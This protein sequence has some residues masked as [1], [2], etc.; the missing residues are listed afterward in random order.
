MRMR[1]AS[2]ARARRTMTVT[3]SIESASDVLARAS[4]EA[5]SMAGTMT[6]SPRSTSSCESREGTP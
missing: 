3:S 2:Q 1:S 4:K 6:R 5:A